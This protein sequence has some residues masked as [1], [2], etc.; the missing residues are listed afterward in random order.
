MKTKLAIIACLLLC[1]CS[2]VVERKPVSAPPPLPS[3]LVPKARAG[4]VVVDSD[5]LPIAGSGSVYAEN[6]ARRSDGLHAFVSTAGVFLWK[7]AGELA[8]YPLPDFVHSSPDCD[9]AGQKLV[10][11]D[12]GVGIGRNGPLQIAEL[13]VETMDFAVVFEMGDTNSRQ[14]VV[15]GLASGGCVVVSWTSAN[16]SSFDIAYKSPFTGQWSAL[17][18]D[19]APVGIPASNWTVAQG[20]DGL[21][22]VFG[23]HDFATQ[24]M[25]FRFAEGAMGLTFVDEDLLFFEGYPHNGVYSEFAPM[26][27]VPYLNAQVDRTRGRVVIGYQR[28]QYTWDCG[29]IQS[30]A[31]VAA[32]YPDKR[33]EL[34][35]NVEEWSGHGYPLFV[36]PRPDRIYYAMTRRNNSPCSNV[37]R[38]FFSGGW[39]DAAA[40]NPFL[41]ASFDGWIVRRKINADWSETYE[42]GKLPLPPRVKVKD[43]G[44]QI[45]VKWDQQTLTDKLEA[46]DDLGSWSVVY[47][48]PPPYVVDKGAGKFYRV[49]P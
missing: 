17:H 19:H 11:A 41:A 39:G 38:F 40:C 42:L 18:H 33:K 45:E 22:Y 24:I 35:F 30:P 12:I 32:V 29:V 5:W 46:S 16:S 9:F 21:I 26:G 23:V 31:L 27:E 3:G 1:S 4:A 47:V 49:R 37:E 25:L 48:G 44:E 36:F 8:Q 2:S 10:L 14:P 20:T 13:D 7:N 28:F 15:R 43:L 34:L 6:I